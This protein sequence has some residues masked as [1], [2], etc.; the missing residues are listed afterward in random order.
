MHRL[1]SLLSR[2][3]IVVWHKALKIK[4][5][6]LLQSFYYKEIKKETNEFIP[7]KAFAQIG[8]FVNENLGWNHI[9]EWRER[10]EQVGIRE[11][12]YQ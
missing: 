12:S 10:R 9:S 11:L 1:N 3:W 7:T 8:V 6:F 5:W 2:I 4:F